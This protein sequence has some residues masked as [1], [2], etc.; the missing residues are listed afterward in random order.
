L[1]FPFLILPSL[2]AATAKD[3]VALESSKNKLTESKLFKNMVESTF[4]SM[5]STGNGEVTKDELYAGLLIVHLKLAKF[6]GA[7][8]CYPPDKPTCDKL[9]DAGDHDD[10]G[11]IDKDEFVSIMAVCCAQ[12]LSRMVMYYLILLLFVPYASAHIVDTL[13][14]PNGGYLESLLETIVGF[15]MFYIAVPVAWDFI[16]DLSR[17]KLEQKPVSTKAT[18]KATEGEKKDE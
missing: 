7:A 3:S 1:T 16:D 12:I 18:T 6:A 13:F 10:S 8:A 2:P 14:I 17:S 5:D 11:T 15:A 4:S 9:F